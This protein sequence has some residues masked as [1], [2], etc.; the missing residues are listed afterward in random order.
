MTTDCLLNYK[1]STRKLQVRYML[2]SWNCSQ[3]VIIIWVNWC[4]NESFLQRFT[5]TVVFEYYLDRFQFCVLQSNIISSLMFALFWF[6]HY[7]FYRLTTD[8]YRM[9]KTKRSWVNLFECTKTRKMNCTNWEPDW[10]D[11]WPKVGSFIKGYCQIVGC[12]L[13]CWLSLLDQLNQQFQ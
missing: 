10:Q 7:L 3:F 6:L 1:F 13:I 5:C 9:P 8:C 2:C 11:S 4:K 12:G